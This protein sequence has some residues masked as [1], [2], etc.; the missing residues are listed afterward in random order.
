[1]DLCNLSRRFRPR[2]FA[3][4]VR[5]KT[6]RNIWTL[7]HPMPGS[8]SRSAMHARMRRHKTKRKMQERRNARSV[9]QERRGGKRD[10]GITHVDILSRV[11]SLGCR[12]RGCNSLILRLSAFVC[13]CAHLRAFTCVL[14][15]FSESIRL[16]LQHPL[17]LHPFCGTL[18]SRE[19]RRKIDGFPQRLRNP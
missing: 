6:T 11:T 9:L 12:K 5:G 13:I 1:M 17:L 3:A 7:F 15:P 2:G 14:G 16:R 4:S 8:K 18:R 19:E 10:V